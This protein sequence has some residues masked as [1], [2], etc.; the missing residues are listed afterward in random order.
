M[1][2]SLIGVRFWAEGH[3]DRLCGPVQHTV[4][5]FPCLRIGPENQEGILLQGQSAGSQK[6]NSLVA[7]VEGGSFLV[8][9]MFPILLLQFRSHCGQS[10]P[11]SR[12]CFAPLQ[13]RQRFVS[14]VLAGVDKISPSYFTSLFS[15]MMAS[16][17]PA[18]PANVS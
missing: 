4:E 3:S 15:H 6:L 12:P 17:T 16:M 10:A 8:C 1:R 2:G 14:T 9:A 11:C 13:P 5:R 18:N 7:D